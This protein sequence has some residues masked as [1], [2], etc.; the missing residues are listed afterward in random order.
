MTARTRH[1]LDLAAAVSKWL[2]IATSAILVLKGYSDLQKHDTILATSVASVVSTQASEAELHEHFHQH[3]ARLERRIH[4]LE[5]RL[6]ARRPR[7]SAGPAMMD[8]LQVDA[9]RPGPVAVLG[10]IVT[11]PIRWL[12]G[13]IRKV[14]SR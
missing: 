14:G 1:R 12:A 2:G 11:G 5:Q 7:S 3:L 6:G 10:R 13:L 8:T 4:V 9:D